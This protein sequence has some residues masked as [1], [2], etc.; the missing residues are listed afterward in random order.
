MPT[1]SRKHAA[2]SAWRMAQYHKADQARNRASESMERAVCAQPMLIATYFMCTPCTAPI[3]A[4]LNAG[5]SRTH[6][7]HFANAPWRRV[8][9]SFFAVLAKVEAARG[10][11]AALY[12]RMLQTFGPQLC[13]C[14]A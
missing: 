1:R 9:G 13:V 12:K 2:I 11:S 8:G 10:R 3:F 4:A 14:G 5:T 6:R 7:V